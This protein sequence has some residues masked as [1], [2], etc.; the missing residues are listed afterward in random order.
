MKVL[1][2][3]IGDSGLVEKYEVEHDLGIEIEY[4]GKLYTLATDNGDSLYL[5][6]LN[7]RLVLRP[8]SSNSVEIETE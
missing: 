4:N 6:A 8:A 7:G 3:K 5:R 2:K 1:L